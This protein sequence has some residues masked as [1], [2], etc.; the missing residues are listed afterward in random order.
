MRA[1]AMASS[2]RCPCERLPPRSR[3]SGV[4][5]AGQALDEPRRLRARERALERLRARPRRRAPRA[6]L[7]RTVPAKRNGSCGTSPTWRRSARRSHSRTSTPV[8]QHLALGDV[9]GAVHE[10][11]HRGLAL[12]G[13]PDERHAARRAPTLN[14]QSRSTQSPPVVREPHVAGTPPRAPPA[15]A[16]GRRRGGRRRSRARCRAARTPARPTTMAAC[17]TVYLAPRSRMG[18]KNRFVYS[19]KATR[20]PK[21]SAPATT[22]PPPYQTSRATAAEPMRL[23]RGVERGVVDGRA[24]LRGAEV[25]VERG[26]TP[27]P[28]AARARRAGSPSCP[29]AT[30]GGTR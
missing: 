13:R 14:E 28:P 9:V 26:R 5:A 29:G 16:G 3:T 1:R 7:S 21:V 24:E 10:A 15:G 23:H 4:E 17:M 30:P 25:A 27:P 8:H 11:R 12:A 2:C 22:S 18:R 6:R 19:M 20:P